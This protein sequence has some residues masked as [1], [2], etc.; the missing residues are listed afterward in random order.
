MNIKRL[1][2]GSLAGMAVLA[3][4]AQAQVTADEAKQLGA[5]LTQLGAVKAANKEGTIPAYTGGLQK[6]PGG[7]KAGSGVWADPFK[8]EAAVLR[9]D[10]KNYQQHGD[11]L[12]DGQKELFKKH[13]G[14]YMD[15]YPTHRTAAVPERVLANTVRN[16]TTCKTAK[17]GLAVDQACRGGIPFPIA[18]TGNEMMWNQQLRYKAD[19]TTRSSRSW[20]VDSSGKAVMTSQQQTF[21]ETPYYHEDLDGRDDQ[22]YWR[23]YSVTSAP[24]R[25][26][27][28]VTGLMDFLDPTQKPRRAWSYA[29]GQ[30]RIKLA[31]EFSYDTPVASMG[32]VTLFDELFVF[33]GQMDRFDFKLV[34]KKEMYV[35]YNAYKLYFGCGVEEQFKEKYP[36][37]ACWRWELHRMW[38]VEATLKQGFRHAYAK[39]TYY[40]DEDSY[41][42]MLYDA[43]DRSG[44]L[45]RSIFNS[46][47]QL[48]DVDAPYTVKNVIFDFNKGMY[49][50]VNDGLVGGYGVVAKPRSNRDLNPEAIVAKETAR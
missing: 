39:R 17:G 5:A 49:A 32:G 3:P 25:K 28:E 38:V 42:A 19:T 16:A 23:T 1:I 18:K 8:D 30:R 36:N 31:P 2:I 9:I 35:P 37:P 12:S 47:I 21:E 24:I 26:A 20:V 13:P 15:V 6:A 4:A 45:Y 27:G 48:Y 46:M 11:K 44:Q 34:G 41:G 33:S 43:Y 7:F 40:I 22:M 50:L 29:P 10:A 14:F